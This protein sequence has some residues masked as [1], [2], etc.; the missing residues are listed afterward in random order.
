MTMTEDQET[1]CYALSEDCLAPASRP[2]TEADF[3]TVILEKTVKTDGRGLA[4]T[5]YASIVPPIVWFELTKNGESINRYRDIKDAIKGWN[6]QV[7]P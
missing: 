3:A 4:L 2:L 5:F 6:E 7:N 1:E